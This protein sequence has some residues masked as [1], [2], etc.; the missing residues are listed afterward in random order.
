MP[1]DTSPERIDALLGVT[2]TQ[3]RRHGRSVVQV[4]AHD[5]LI[6][7]GT[8]AACERLRLDWLLEHHQPRLSAP[9]PT[10]GGKQLWGDIFVQR[11][12]RIQEHVWSPNCRLLNPHNRRIAH[13]TWPQCRTAFERLRLNRDIQPHNHHAVVILH[14][15]IRSKESVWGLSQAAREA[16]YEVVDVNYPSTRRPI[17][18]NAEQLNRLLDNLRGIDT[19]SFITHSMGAAVVRTAMASPTPRGW[20]ERIRV[21]R[22]AMIF[23]PSRGSHKANR[24]ATNPVVRWFM[25]PALEELTTHQALNIPRPT[26]PFAIIAGQRDTTVL[27]E[28]A[29]MDGA[30]AFITLDVEHTF[31][32]NHPKVVNATLNYIQHG[33]LHHQES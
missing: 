6:G 1:S 28:E 17:Q 14:G 8:W 30:E 21:D 26:F 22:C 23:P 7:S 24:W 29:R 32:M 19:V 12:W 31:G 2:L 13:G 27:I 15:L 4:R 10:W 16:G 33:S 20:W 11:G 25:G 18:D 3:I 5:R 9:L